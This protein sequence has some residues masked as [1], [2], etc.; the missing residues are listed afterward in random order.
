MK[1]LKNH[2]ILY[3]ADCPLCR[4]YTGA[5]IRTEMLDEKGRVPFQITGGAFCPGLDSSRAKNEIALLNREN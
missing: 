3:D 5:F 2:T 1:T 4:A